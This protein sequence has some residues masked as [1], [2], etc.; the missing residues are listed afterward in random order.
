MVFSQKPFKRD[1]KYPFPSKAAS[2]AKLDLPL[3]T[4]F[5]ISKQDVPVPLSP[6]APWNAE[7][8]EASSSEA[9]RR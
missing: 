8:V 4:L 5:Q 3:E 2:T 9:Q 6:S 7:K 1:Q